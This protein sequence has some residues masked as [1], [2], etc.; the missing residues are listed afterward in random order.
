MYKVYLKGGALV[1][2]LFFDYPEDDN[3]FEDIEHTYMLG[4]AIKVSPVLEADVT[5]TFQA[6]F[7]KGIWADLNQQ[8]LSIASNG[9]KITLDQ[10]YAYTNIHLKEGKIIPF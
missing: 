2:P 9:E 8:N 10:S 7:P 6:Y 1:Y 3:T 5:D 4:D